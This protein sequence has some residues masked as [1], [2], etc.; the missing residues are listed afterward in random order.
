METVQASPI[1][2]GSVATQESKIERSDCQ[3]KVPA[4]APTPA[5]APTDTWVV[6][7]GRPNLLAIS[8]KK[9]VIKLAVSPCVSSIRLTFWLMV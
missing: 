1:A 4:L 6:E 8:T 5:I 3:F 7:T 9:V 2:S